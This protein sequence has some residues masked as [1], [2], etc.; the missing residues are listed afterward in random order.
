[1]RRRGV[2]LR[3]ILIA[4]L[5]AAIAWLAFNRQLVQPA[6]LERALRG[7]GPFAPVLFIL[8]Y[9]LATVLFAPG[10]ILTLA[11][12]A[13]FGPLWGT[14]WN[15]IGATLGATLAFLVA[16]YVASGWVA[17]HAGDR[18]AR[19]IRGVEDEGWRFVAFV[20]LVP[21]FPFNVVN[22]AFGL[23]RIGLAEYVITSFVCMIPGVFA[24]TYL[25]YAGREAAYGQGTIRKGLLA[26]ALLATVAFL[27][28]LVRR[29]RAK[30]AAGS[31]GDKSS[32]R[33]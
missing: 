28:R 20:R 15:L 23:T 16:R 8:C 3:V 11:G 29:L 33:P 18:L 32:S 31:A 27:P 5:S 22:Y 2:I 6:A 30:R 17:S 13:F 25:G 9:A 10:V 24:Y 14:L 7:F 19:L 12:G 21:L 26:L 4:G 1:M